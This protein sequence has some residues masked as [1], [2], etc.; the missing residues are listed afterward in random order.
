M[1]TWKVFI[2]YAVS[3]VGF[4]AIDFL[5]LGV[6]N[7][8]VYKPG[9]GHLLAENVNAVPALVFYVGYVAGVLIFAI[10]PGLDAGSVWKTIGLAAV[11]GFVAYGTYDFTNYATLKDWPLHIVLIDLV[12]GMSV[13]T[14]TALIGYYTGSKLLN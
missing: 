6:M 9:I 11:L 1:E 4:L 14:L 13:T 10:M 3:L 5:W 7:S 12:W 2:M 8:R